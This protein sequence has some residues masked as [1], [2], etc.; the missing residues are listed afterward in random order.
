MSI[1]ETSLPDQAYQTGEAYPDL[2]HV[3]NILL[4]VLCLVIVGEIIALLAGGALSV[5][6]TII[7]A[8][9][10]LVLALLAFLARSNP[11]L[12]IIAALIIFVSCSVLVAVLKPNFLGGSIIIKVFVLIYLARAIPEAKILQKPN[13]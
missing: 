6:V 10:V 7:T 8:V 9:E 12:T 13:H 2:N 1:H 4:E 3:R 5:E 11:F